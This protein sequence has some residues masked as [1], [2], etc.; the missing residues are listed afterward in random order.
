MKALPYG[1]VQRVSRGSTRE[2]L[3]LNRP[4]VPLTGKS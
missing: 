4:T 3:L 1:S 2:G